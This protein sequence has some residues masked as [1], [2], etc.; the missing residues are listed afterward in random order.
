MSRFAPFENSASRPFAAGDFVKLRRD[1]PGPIVTAFAGDWGQVSK[2]NRDGSLDLTFAGYSRPR[3]AS[4]P[5]AMGVPGR[6]V[7]RCD[8]YGKPLSEERGRH[9]AGSGA[10]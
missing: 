10:G 5:R 3:T 9:W 7:E 4:S 2:V 1:E 6:I 8:A